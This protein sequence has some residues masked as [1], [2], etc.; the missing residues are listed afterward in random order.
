MILFNSI[1][2]VSADYN[3]NKE[4]SY[5]PKLVD[6]AESPNSTMSLLSNL[7]NN[8]FS[9]NSFEL[10]DTEKLTTVKDRM[11]MCTIKDTKHTSLLDDDDDDDDILGFDSTGDDDG[12]LVQLLYL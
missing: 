3:L 2:L 5:S 1:F 9:F 4:N 12:K 6:I 8:N 11:E 10:S 7:S